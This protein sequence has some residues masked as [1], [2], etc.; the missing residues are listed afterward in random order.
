MLGTAV[1]TYL[2]VCNFMGFILMGLDKQKA[3]KKKWRISEKT[4]FLMAAVG[5]SIGSVLGMYFFHH[6]T[7]HKSFVYGMPLIMCFQATMFAYFSLR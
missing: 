3:R 1:V 7:K 5:G 4:L 6:K 2:L